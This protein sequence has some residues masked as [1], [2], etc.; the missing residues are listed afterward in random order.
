MSLSLTSPAFDNGTAIP[1]IYT[2]DGTNLSPPLS[3]SGLPPRTKSLALTIEDP[4]APDPAAPQR[5]WTHWV[6]YNLPLSINSLPAGALGQDLPRGSRQGLN[7]W[8]EASYGGPCPPV[9]QH[10]YI[11]KLYALDITLP[12]IGP[13]TRARLE[14]VM[15]PH[16]IEQAEL[17]GL[18]ERK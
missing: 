16:I 4:D 17:V 9:G 2:C 14:Q 8:E 7:D 5:T 6:V 12:D 13:C 10:R 3:W 11:H 1:E 18:Y 15:R